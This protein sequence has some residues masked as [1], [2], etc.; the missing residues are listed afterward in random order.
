MKDKQIHIGASVHKRSIAFKG[1]DDNAWGIRY[2]GRPLGKEGHDNCSD[3][4]RHY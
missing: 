2:K 3:I 1:H 4:S